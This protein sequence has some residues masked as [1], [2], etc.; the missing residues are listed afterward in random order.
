MLYNVEKNILSAKL[1]NHIH[2]IYK[3]LE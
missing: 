2:E 3:K 1:G